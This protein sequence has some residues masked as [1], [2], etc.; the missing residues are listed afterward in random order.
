VGRYGYLLLAAYSSADQV[1]GLEHLL[2]VCRSAIDPDGRRLIRHLAGW[3]AGADP[4]RVPSFAVALPSPGGLAVLL[5]G[6]AELTSTS[7]E[8]SME[9]SGRQ[10]AAWVD[11]ILPW[12][13]DALVMTGGGSEL[14]RPDDSEPWLDLRAGVVPGAAL[15]VHWVRDGQA[16]TATP[17]IVADFR[18][19]S[20][21]SSADAGPAPSLD[22]GPPPTPAEAPP[23]FESVLLIEPEPEPQSEPAPHLSEPS[24]ET[25]QE[26]VMVKGVNCKRGHFND[27]NAAFCGGCGISMVQQ[28]HQLVAGP[29]P[30]LG[31][32]VLDDGAT[33][34]MDSDY[35]IGR[36][37]ENDP[38]VQDGAAR[39]LELMD[40]EGTVSRSHALVC[41]T[42]WDVEL[43]DRSANG[44]YVVVPGSTDWAQ[45]PRDLPVRIAPG[46]R[47]RIGSRT[48]VFD[49]HVKI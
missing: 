28:T 11:R 20:D 23:T 29:R 30:P 35:V 33:F 26:R 47:I 5:H 12:P 38:L 7:G 34:T 45:L 17:M 25:Q 1:D 40:E 42:G 8:S 27:P 44:T 19:V 36:E 13:I 3:L 6:P 10:S 21:E 14:P 24:A 49:S 37:P 43:R 32:F 31:V 9:L 22:V 4:E 46:T 18:P 2:N 39:A 15:A 16:A 48:L 41:L